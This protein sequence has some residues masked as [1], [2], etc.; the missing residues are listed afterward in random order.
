MHTKGYQSIF[1]CNNRVEFRRFVRPLL[2][3]ELGI[4]YSNRG[5]GGSF[6]P[7]H[8]TLSPDLRLSIAATI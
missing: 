5:R 4:V 3:P 6:K 8:E 1:S 2:K 7:P